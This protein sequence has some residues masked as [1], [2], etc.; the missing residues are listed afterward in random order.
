[1][2]VCLHQMQHGTAEVKAYED[3]GR[4]CGLGQY[5][6]F[7]SL[8]I[9][10]IKIGA[11]GSGRILTEAADEAML[12]RKENARKLGEQLGVKL[13]APMMLLLVLVMLLVIVPAFM[14]MNYA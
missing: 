14:A 3:F 6:K 4:R 5:L 12:L 1:M 7:S 11:R 13:L 2:I 8:L 10:N 9:Q